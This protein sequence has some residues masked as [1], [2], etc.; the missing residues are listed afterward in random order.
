MR[1][2]IFTSFLLLAITFS[3]AYYTK[4]V[5]SNK[6][7]LI[8]VPFVS[9]FLSLLPE[10]NLTL[11]GNLIHEIKSQFNGYKIVSHSNTIR[12]LSVHELFSSCC[13]CHLSSLNCPYCQY[14]NN[15]LCIY[16]LRNI[17]HKLLDYMTSIHE[18]YLATRKY[19]SDQ[20]YVK[21]SQTYKLHGL[22]RVY[23]PEFEKCKTITNKLSYGT[24]YSSKCTFVYHSKMECPNVTYFRPGDYC[25]W[26]HITDTV[27]DTERICSAP[28]LTHLSLPISANNFPCIGGSALNIPVLNEYIKTASTGFLPVPLGKTFNDYY[29]SVPSP[30][31]VSN[32]IRRL[33]QEVSYSFRADYGQRTV[34][35]PGDHIYNTTL[36]SGNPSYIGD[37]LIQKPCRNYLPFNRTHDICEEVIFNP[38]PYCLDYAFIST[39]NPPDEIFSTKIVRF[40][41]PFSNFTCNMFGEMG[42]CVFRHLYGEFSHNMSK[43]LNSVEKNL[44]ADLEKLFDDL[45][46]KI[47]R[48]HTP[49]YYS[50]KTYKS[51]SLGSWLSGLFYDLM[52]PFFKLFIDIVLRDVLVPLT[53]CFIAFIDVV[54]DL[55]SDISQKLLNQ[56]SKLADS[57]SLLLKNL[58]NLVLGLLL[59][60]ESHLLLFEYTMAFLV[61]VVYFG[62]DTLCSLIV[63]ILITFVFGINRKSPSLILYFIHRDF[64]ELFNFSWYY[65]QDFTYDYHFTY[66]DGKNFLTYFFINSSI[67][68]DNLY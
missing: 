16:P 1:C 17:P 9:Q 52:E 48:N 45:L 21:S 3:S 43:T 50:S 39:H 44:T 64:H 53:D 38:Y 55:I 63:V 26:R 60:L 49:N 28:S 59:V 23:Y 31:R 51:K 19:A 12:E 24:D 66:Y 62:L 32:L 14:S 11:D 37:L 42:M 5:F 47:G 8:P 20:V 4:N 25:D 46:D 58:T 61:L 6:L 35:Y 30:Y 15:Y 2:L 18:Y 34:C 7:R 68:R 67:I 36:Y 13:V 22:F 10:R 54:A 33:S 27:N 56:L 57:L 65:S 29:F 41:S 40:A